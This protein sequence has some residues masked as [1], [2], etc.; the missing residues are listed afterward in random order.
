[1][2]YGASTDEPRR[3][4]LCRKQPLSSAAPKHT[5]RLERVAEQLLRLAAVVDYLRYGWSEL[6]ICQV[7]QCQPNSCARRARATILPY[8]EA[9]RF[10]ASD[11]ESGLR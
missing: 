5:G 10:M 4:E 3:G 7:W 2:A 11:L 9:T 6:A 1:M 8:S